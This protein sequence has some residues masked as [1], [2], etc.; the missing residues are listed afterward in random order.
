[1]AT[2]QLGPKIWLV[3]A[4]HATPIARSIPKILSPDDIHMLGWV[5]GVYT[6]K[7]KAEETILQ[8]HIG[9]RNY[10]KNIYVCGEVTDQIAGEAPVLKII[11][12]TVD[13]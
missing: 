11:E 2:E 3:V 8:G 6:S 7:K 12:Y 10:D 9:Y 5:V 4:D 1:M 13:E